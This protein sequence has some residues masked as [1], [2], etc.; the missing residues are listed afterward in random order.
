MTFEHAGAGALDYLPCQYGTSKLVFRGPGR[1]LDRDYA[2]FIGGTETYGKFIPRPFP[3]L[4]EEMTGIPSINFGCV[5]AGIDAF[6]QDAT[7]IARA[8]RARVIV[9][10]VMG[11]QYVSNCFYS[12]HPRRNDRFITAHE[13]LRRLFPS[14]DFTEFNFIGHVLSALERRSPRRFDLVVRAL[15][16]T[17]S[18]RMATILHHMARPAVLLWLE[19]GPDHAHGFVTPAMMSELRPIAAAMIQVRCEEAAAQDNGGMVFTP[20]EAT[21]A[22]GLPNAATHL[23]VA[24]D[25]SAVINDL[26]ARGALKR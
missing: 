15:Q 8:R 18:H 23:R 11:A 4:V 1:H 7:V 16:K 22:V 3:S 20:F 26:S 19:E 25:L 13:P 12:V 14:V 2:L 6:A 10:Q 21:A 17:W 24:Q 5:N 9:L